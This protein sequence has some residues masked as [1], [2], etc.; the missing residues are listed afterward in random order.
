MPGSRQLLHPAAYS[1]DF[2]PIKQLYA[3]LKALLRKAGER[4]LEQNRTPS[5]SLF[6]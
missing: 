1:P 4:S 6:P 3:K 5:R 2:N